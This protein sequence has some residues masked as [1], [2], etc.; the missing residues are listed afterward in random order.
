MR[1][2]AD[3][4][5]ALDA[6]VVARNGS[7]H[8]AGSVAVDAVVGELQARLTIGVLILCSVML[9]GRG[10]A[11]AGTTSELDDGLAWSV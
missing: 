10:G 5:L 11:A 4:R 8:A 2:I 6:V 7:G 9:L 3:H 1:R